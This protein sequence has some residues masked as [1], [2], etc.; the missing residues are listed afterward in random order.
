MIPCLGGYMGKDIFSKKSR[1]SIRKLNIGVCSVL[2]G[3]LIMIGHTAQADETTSDGATVATTAVS[4]SQGDGASTTTP[5][6]TAPES[7]ATTTVA[8]AATETVTSMSVAPTTS[9]APSVA[10]SSEAPAS[11]SAT[12]S[13]PASSAATS[14]SPVVASEVPGSTN[15]STAKPATASEASRSV[16]ASTASVTTASSEN[17]IANNVTVSETANVPR[18]RRRRDTGGTSRSVDETR[19][20]RVTVTKDNFDSFFKEGGT[21]NY[22][23]TSGTIK[24]TDD[25]SGQVGSAYLRFKIDPREDFTFTGKVDIGDKYEGHTVGSRLGGDGVGF[26]F[27]TGNVDTIGQSGASIGMGTIKNAFGF[28]LDSWH[29]T[30]NPNANQNASADPRYGGNAWRSNAFGSFYSSNN[31]GR[32]TTSSSAAKALNPKPNGEW[33]DFKIEYKG[34][35]KEFIVTY[36]SEKWSTNLKTANASIMEPTAKTALNNSNA[37]Y[38][39]SFLGSTGS[40]TN[41]Q[42]VQIEKFEF[43][44]PQI[45]QVAFY[46]E[47][48]NELAASSAIPGD[49]DQVVNLSNIEAVQ[50]AITKLKTKGYTLKEVNSDKAETYNSGANTVTLRSGGQ[51]LK[52]VFAVPTPEVTKTLP[53]DGGM[54]RN[55]GIKSTDRTL[56]GTGTPGATINIKVAGNTVVDNVTVESN[57]KWTATLPT[58][59]NSNVTTQDQLVPKDSLVVTQKIGVS[60]SEAATVDVALGESSVVPSTESKDQQ[61]IVAETTTVTLKV[62]HDAGVTY[63]DYPKTGGRSEVAIKRDSIPGAWASKDASKAVVTSYSTDG[64]VDTIVLEMKEQIQPGK[65]KVISNIKE[66]KY[67]SPVG[68]KEINVEEKP[69]TTPPV[70]PTV[71][72]VKV[73]ATNL[74]GTAEAN[75]TV[76]A[77]LPNGSKVTATAGSDGS[78]TIP[79][80]GLNEGDTISVTATDAA[81]NKSTPSVVT[82]KENVRPVV[83]IPYDDKANQIIYLYSG[84]ENN[85]ELKVTDNSGNIA[86]A[87]LVFA[88]DNRTGL[89]TEDAGYLNGKTKSALYLKANRFGSE[90]TATEANPAIIKLT[91]NIP[92]G[93]YTDG[94]GMTRYIYAEDLAGNTNYDS[95][96]AAGDTGAPGRIRF[97]W[98]P[99]TFKYNVQAPSTPIVTNTVPSAADLANAVKVANPTFSDKIDSVTLNG[100]NVTVTYKDGSTDTLS[101]ASVFD[102]EAVAPSVTPV[103]NPSSLTTPEKDAVKAAVKVANP[104]ATTVVV[105]NDGST[106]LT[107]SN[108]STANLT[109]AQTVK[110][111]D[112]N[113]VQEPAAKTPVQNTSALTQP[114]KDAVKSAVETANP[115]ATKVEVGDN[116]DTTVTFP[117][118]TTATLT[119]DKTVYV[120]DNGELP[121][122]IDLPK[123]IITKW[124]DE[125]GNELKP[126]DAKAPVELGGANEALEHGEIEGYVFDRTVTDKVEG[127]VTHIFKRVKAEADTTAPTAP[128]VNP[129]KAG[130]TA[131]TGTAEAGSTVEVTLPD[132][133]KV[134]ATAG[135]DGNYSV[136]VSGLKEGDTVSVTATDEAGNKSD[137]TTATVAKA[138]DKTAPDA[139][140]VNP[141]KA[142][143]TAVTGTAEAGSTVEVTK[144]S[145]TADQDGNFSVP[146]SGLNEGDTVSVTATDKAGNTSNPTSVTVGK[147]TDTTAPTAPVVNPVKA[148]TT[149]VT[150]T[151]EAGSTVEVTLPDGS[152]VSAKADQYGNFSVPV[153]GL[154]EGDIVSVTA[155]DEAGNTSNPTSVTVGKGLDTTAPAKPVVDTDLTG[156]AGTRTPIDVIAEPGTKIELF[157]K[158]GNKIGEATA[159]TNGKATII[160]TVAIPEGNVT[161][162]ATDSSGNVSDASAPMLATRGGSTDTFNNSKGSDVTPTVVK[163]SPAVDVQAV[164]SSDKHMNLKARATISAAQKDASTLPATGEEASTAAVV[165]G[166]VLAAFGLTLAGK[167]KKED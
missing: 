2:L 165:L 107:Y 32:V 146:V 33:V 31:A 54:L 150:G 47:A 75:S 26:V 48:G 158:D 72:S 167:R 11:T 78:F 131:V 139:P 16:T 132:G 19:L 83:N 10:V 154:K 145:A 76:E 30:S 62:P 97:V 140:V 64:F 17:A 8:P 40:G 148:G 137:A 37:T 113:G 102:I 116:G 82:V 163:P 35:S 21:A 27:H 134:S 55:G 14:T 126:T 3:T 5:P 86:K 100:T 123:L 87:F 51:L 105:G 43:T 23:E 135:Q 155:T 129:V 49:R 136:S 101:A 133:S 159:D 39:L 92:N 95:V 63:F 114:E 161:A 122:S 115:S 46:D 45:V 164:D 152:K 25:V 70:A 69:D 65:A 85:I 12:S 99:Q 128:V 112:A 118:G 80:S 1:F 125:N 18:V 59:L 34:Q 44:A 90:T 106:T 60:E 157:D 66:T 13:A 130:D 52:Y 50:K 103:K 88:Q 67:S 108:G 61:S 73:G 166:G 142:G 111:A 15:V 81:S 151:A 147:G 89:G 41:L 28:K 57:G 124:V 160:P 143:D 24:L 109:P 141:V 120:S 121:D 74:T 110:A 117:D 42:R 29:N 153:S 144:V 36:G 104:D 127:T 20:D 68:W 22:D 58:G 77:T 94:T 84:E 98:K 9:V 79:V 91:A 156:K 6:I 56:S 138:D 119:G 162:R 4:A 93:S 96:G 53:S 149:A 7:A 38:A 71:N